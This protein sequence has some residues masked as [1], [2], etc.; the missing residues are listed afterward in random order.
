MSDP[1][2]ALFPAS[3]F[4]TADEAREGLRQLHR[5]LGRIVAPHGIDEAGFVRL[6]GMEQWVAVR[7][8][9]RR[10][11]VLLFLH[12]GPNHPVSDIAYAYQRPWEDFF[13][14][15]NW[16][17]R[18]CG[19]SFGSDDEAEA[20]RA[21]LTKKQWVADALELVEHLCARFG[22]RQLIVVG[23][24]WGTVLALELARR[25]PER[26]HVVGLQGLAVQWLASAQLLCDTLIAEAEARGD[27][28]EAA[29]LRAA[30]PV[31]PPGDIEALMAWVQRFRRPV[32]DAH[33][34]HN[35]A[36]AGDGWTRR[37]DLLRWVSPDLPPAHYERDRRLWVE[38]ADEKYARHVAGMAAAMHWDA[39]RDVGTVFQVPVLVMQGTHDWQTHTR[40]ARAYFDELQ[41]PW[42]HWVE[43]PHA[44][45]ALNI[46]QP[47][48]AVV[49]LV[50]YA[51]AAAQGRVPEGVQRG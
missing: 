4:T 47:G 12:G 23:Q 14:V 28:A 48:L 8:Q 26:L 42:K 37:M 39:R 30:G 46:E 31:P 11:P 10:A 33:T 38:R 49:A 51:L 24:S 6:G 36:G 34:W 7:G 22:Q 40:L 27:E 20:V 9:D 3:A 35:I 15:A 1:E 41:A 45:H 21:T 18:G 25:R 19:R 2:A 5:D 50:Q 32:P 44:A 17:Q 43:F 13:V 29:H 16:D